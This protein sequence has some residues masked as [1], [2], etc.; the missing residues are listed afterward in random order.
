MKDRELAALS[1]LEAAA[2]DVA[3]QPPAPR[4]DGLAALQHDPVMLR[5]RDATLERTYLQG[6][7][8]RNR[9]WILGS[10]ALGFAIVLLFY[11]LDRLFI[12]AEALN[13]VHA[14]RISVLA[15]APL[16]GL[17]GLLVIHR[18]AIAIPFLFTCVAMAGLAWSAIRGL[19]GA[20]AEPYVAFGAAQTVLFAYICMGL[21]FRW[22]ASAVAIT[23]APIFVL[24]AEQGIGSSDFWYTAASLTTIALI[25]SY[26]AFR[27]EWASRERF[28]AQDRFEAEYMRRLAMEHERSEWLSVIAGFTR[29]ELKNAMAGIGSSLELLER[30]SLSASGAA[31]VDRAKRSLQLMRTILTQVANATS[32]ESALELQELEKI[33]LSRLVAGRGDDLRRAD[34]AHRCEFVVKDGVHVLGNADSLLQMLDKLLNNALE[35]SGHHDLIRVS[36]EASNDRALL[37]VLNHGEPLPADIDSLFRPFVSAGPATREGNLGLGLY[38]AQ[39]IARRHGGTIHA[40]PPADRP[41]AVFVVDLPLLAD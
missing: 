41:G 31:Y 39:T 5:F 34:E 35:H 7:Y 13:R 37:T 10:L 22:S 23:L 1:G 12:P 28:L 4:A 26:G 8:D 25:A 6:E 21:P 36:L 14:V 16:L 32:L 33:D 18:A 3:P 11:P 19:S 40:A 27:Q 15:G 17:V 20:S 24:S 30:L 29:H 38:V 9:R 2:T